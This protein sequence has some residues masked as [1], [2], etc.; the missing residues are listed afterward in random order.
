VTRDDL[1]NI[2]DA[3]H[4]INAAQVQIERFSTA[5]QISQAS[6]RSPL[7]PGAWRRGLYSAEAHLLIVAMN[8]VSTALERIDDRLGV[9]T[10]SEGVKTS[11]LLLRNIL[12]HWDEQRDA[13][14]NDSIPKVQSGKRY[15]DRFP[16]STP[17][18]FSASGDSNIG[19]RIGEAFNVVDARRELDAIVDTLEPLWL[20]ALTDVGVL[21]YRGP[22]VEFRPTD[23]FAESAAETA[24][25]AFEGRARV[26]I[27]I[28]EGDKAAILLIA[29]PHPDSDVDGCAWWATALRTPRGWI[30]S[31]GGNGTGGW[32]SIEGDRGIVY[33]GGAAPSGAT[34]VTLLFRGEKIEVP[35][36]DGHYGWASFDALADERIERDF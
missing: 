30:C 34:H 26:A 33:E 10:L 21:P 7:G 27:E 35:V 18:S 29:D 6:S 19:L 8:H 25:E 4:W 13:F 12:E 22:A 28:V 36:V 3:L 17:W 23:T 24:V 31:G 11:T 32:H 15:A 1:Q 9:A 14:S 16:D 2:D 20:Q 5:F